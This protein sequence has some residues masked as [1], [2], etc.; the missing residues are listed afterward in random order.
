M[1]EFS[2]GLAEGV[3]REYEDV[4][5]RFPRCGLHRMQDRGASAMTNSIPHLPYRLTMKEQPKAMLKLFGIYMSGRWLGDV[6]NQGFCLGLFYEGD[7]YLRHSFQALF[8]D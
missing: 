8:Q 1:S 6:L 3:W 7:C 2:R 4:I 5:L